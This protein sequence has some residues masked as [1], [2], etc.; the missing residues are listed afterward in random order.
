MNLLYE[1]TK[2]YVTL[3]FIFSYNSAS[4]LRSQQGS[5]ERVSA[6]SLPRIGLHP[7]GSRE[8]TR[9]VPSRESNLSDKA[10]KALQ[11]GGP[12]DSPGPPPPSPE[13]KTP[14]LPLAGISESD[15]EQK[16]TSR[17]DTHRAR[18]GSLSVVVVPQVNE[19]EKNEGDEDEEEEEVVVVA[20]SSTDIYPPSATTTTMDNTAGQPAP[21]V[22]PTSQ[23]LQLEAA[24]EEAEAELMKAV[25]QLDEFDATDE[26]YKEELKNELEKWSQDGASTDEKQ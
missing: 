17:G 4:R 1:I 9:S 11:D 20:A 16:S 8:N 19:E 7:N 13:A 5:R 26:Q 23:D 2:E 24:L 6:A 10:I 3:L 18:Q 14:K 25:S 12:I 22:I 21:I 15:S